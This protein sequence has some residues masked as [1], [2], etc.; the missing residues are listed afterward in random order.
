MNEPVSTQ[1]LMRYLD[2]ELPP[3]ERRRVEDALAGSLELRRQL[4][5]FRELRFDLLG[6]TFPGTSTEGTVWHRVSLHVARPA[7]RAFIL[8]GF[9]AWLLYALW[10]LASRPTDPWDRLAIAAVA[11]GVLTLLAFVI[12]ER[13]RSW[14]DDA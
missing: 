10:V 3:E 11:I 7:G 1:D 14:S 6:L 12:R 8:A 13:F 9:V 5:V 4:D 2:G